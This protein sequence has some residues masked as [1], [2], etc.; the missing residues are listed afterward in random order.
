LEIISE[1]AKTTRERLQKELR[2]HCRA[3][4]I[5]GLSFT[6]GRHTTEE[7]KSRDD[8]FMFH[9]ESGIG[10]RQTGFDVGESLTK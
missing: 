4:A 6:L 7:Q 5:F 8:Q 1:C 9:V 10:N 3:L 2:A